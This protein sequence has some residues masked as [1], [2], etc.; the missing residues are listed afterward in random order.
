MFEHFC[1][2]VHNNKIIFEYVAEK[3]LIDLDKT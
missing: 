1:R 2:S 3:F